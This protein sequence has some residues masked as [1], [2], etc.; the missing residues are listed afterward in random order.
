MSGDL[1]NSAHVTTWLNSPTTQGEEILF[2][3]A[4]SNALT[5]PDHA[6]WTFTGDFTVELFGVKFADNTALRGLIA[7]YNATGNQRSWNFIYDGAAATDVL[8]V[9][10]SGN[11]STTTVITAN[12]TPTVNQAYNLCFERSGSTV[13]IY[14][15]GTM[16]GSGTFAGSVFEST[17]DMRVGASASASAS[18]HNGRMKAV[19]ITKGVA[20]Y[21]TN[22]SYTVPT[23][24][25]P[26]S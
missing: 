2:A 7:H 18:L 12:F 23:L 4:S 8:Q 21:A 11:G 5:I 6:N 17:A 19:R 13:R 26:T 20:R 1:S 22:G 15:D 10:L 16:I 3:S 9:T 14:V 25:L 24:P